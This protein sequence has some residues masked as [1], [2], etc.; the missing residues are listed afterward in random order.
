MDR[1]MDGWM[2]GQVARLTEG[3][4]VDK[5]IKIQTVSRWMG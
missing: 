5:E 3:H 2:D 4:I 1:W